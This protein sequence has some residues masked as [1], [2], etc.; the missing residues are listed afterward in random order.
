METE[1]LYY[2]DCHLQAFSAAVLSCAQTEKGWETVLSATAFYPEGGGQACDLGT[3]G[4]VNVL[5]VRERGDAIIHLCDG[6]LEVGT[7]VEGRLD[8]ARRFDLM[9]QHS[10]E[11]ILSGLVHQKFGYHNVGFH[12]GAEMME[13]DFDGPISGPDLLELER[14]ANEVVFS[15]LPIRC[16]Y[17]SQEELPSVQYR[18]KRALPWPVRIVEV[19]GTDSCACCGVHV[20]RT[21]EIGLIKI[22]SWMK[23]H[24]GIRI[25]LCCGGRAV[26]LVQGIFEENRRVSQEFSA[27]LLETGAAARKMT[28]ALAAEKL[29]A[30]SLQTA[31]FDS[32]AQG[33]AGKGRVIRFQEGLEPGQLRVL[34]DKLAALC[35]SWAAVYTGAE[36]A[37]NICVIGPGTEDLGKALRQELNARGGG[38]PGSFQGTVP[39]TREAIETLLG[40]YGGAAAQSLPS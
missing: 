27:K 11:H 1:K 38:K 37:Y 39:A 3:L 35:G 31:I 29:R 14:A 7:T 28:E 23:F 15:N 22:V 40:R 34:A 9:Q 13:I 36:G 10:G 19:P 6:P 32:I 16:W 4:A 24:Q 20:G 25:Q 12:V 33:Y 26:K 17:P 30:N 8:W 2:Q 21:G 5:D 18:S